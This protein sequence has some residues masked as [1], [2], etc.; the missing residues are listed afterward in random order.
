[1]LSFP[2]PPKELLILFVIQS[3][4]LGHSRALITNDPLS[5]VV[6]DGHISACL[7]EKIYS[8]HMANKLV[9]RDIRRSTPRGACIDGR[10]LRRMCRRAVARLVLGK[11]LTIEDPECHHRA[12]TAVLRELQL[13]VPDVCATERRQ[14]ASR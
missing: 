7:L 14:L 10:T 13:T 12:K 6:V 5:R 2:L 8:Y 11:K 1:M 9:L 4:D 3:V